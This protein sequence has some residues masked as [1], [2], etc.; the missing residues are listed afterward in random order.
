MVDNHSIDERESG[1]N[2]LLLAPNHSCKNVRGNP[3]SR[4]AWIRSKDVLLVKDLWMV[5][6]LASKYGGNL[7]PAILQLQD[8]AF[9]YDVD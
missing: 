4:L 8:D 6:G 2:L 3:Y 9:L 5:D 1:W 7:P